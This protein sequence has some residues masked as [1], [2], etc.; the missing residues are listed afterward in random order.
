METMKNNMKIMGCV[1][2]LLILS[3]LE[4]STAADSSSQSGEHLTTAPTAIDTQLDTL[5]QAYRSWYGLEIQSALS[6]IP[7]ILIVQESGLTTVRGN[8]RVYY[9]LPKQSY[10]HLKNLLHAVLGFYGIMTSNARS[11]TT[12]NWN[13]LGTFRNDLARSLDLIKAASLTDEEK[14][15][16]TH[17]LT[18]LLI[19]TDEILSRRSLNSDKISTLLSNI[20][21]DLETLSQSMG[22]QHSRHL[23][24]T[25]LKIKSEATSQEWNDLVAVVAGHQTPRRGN[26]ETAVTASILGK[27]LLGE[28]IFYAE[29]IN[30]VEGALGFLQTLVGDSQLSEAVFKD[31]TRMWRDLFA[32]VSRQY[33]SEDFYTELKMGTPKH[34]LFAE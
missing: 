15:L 14:K 27:E 32:P 17:S 8:Q 21:P 12:P 3:T 5:N 2:C 33:V 18:E 31:P 22:D 4:P 29:N 25:L 26:L 10:N 24:T 20:R 19:G 13:E 34:H 9:P 11:G 16:A 7:L 30:S 1:S 23:A 6:R 28:R